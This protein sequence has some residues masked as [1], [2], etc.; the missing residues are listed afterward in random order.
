MSKCIQ[1]ICCYIVI[2]KWDS[3]LPLVVMKRILKLRKKAR[4]I[5]VVFSEIESY[6]VLIDNQ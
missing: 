5:K 3:N 2:K 6:K 1:N 4:D